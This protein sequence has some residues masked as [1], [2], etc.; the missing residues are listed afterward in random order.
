MAIINATNANVAT[1][2]QDNYSINGKLAHRWSAGET[3]LKVGYAYFDEDRFETEY[4][5]EFDRALPRFTGDQTLSAIKDKEFSVKLEHEV[6]LGEDA[7]LVFGGLPPKSGPLSEGYYTLPT[8]FADRSNDWRLAREEIF[9]PVL[10]AMPFDD[11]DEV[12]GMANDN[13]YGL[14]ASIWSN[15]LAAVHR[16]IPRIKSGSVWVNCHSALDPA[17]PFG[18][19]KMS[20]VGREMGAAAIEHYTELK[21]VMIRY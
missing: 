21:S 3:S 15:D 20:G 18:G 4:E 10:V 2:D 1:I 16:M 13:P 14:G 19:Y 9:G 8:V 6:A 7:K 5:V 17:L 11:I 12:I